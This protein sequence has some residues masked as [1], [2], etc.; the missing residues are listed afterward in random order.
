MDRLSR[1]LLK[2]GRTKTFATKNGG[3][4]DLE[5]QYLIVGIIAHEVGDAT[6][7]VH[8]VAGAEFGLG[9][10]ATDL[11]DVLPGVLEK[12]KRQADFKKATTWPAKARLDAGDG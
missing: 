12:L 5:Q 11:P 10:I 4:A 3:R 9:L 1:G 8:S 6:V 2:R 7:E